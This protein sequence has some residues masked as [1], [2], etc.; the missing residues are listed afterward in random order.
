MEN[1]RDRVIEVLH[2]VFDPELPVNIFELGL[3]YDIKIGD[4]NSVDIIMTLTAPAC[5]VAGDIIFEVQ[6]KVSAVEGVTDA[7]VQL[8]FDPPWTKDMMSEEARLELGF[9]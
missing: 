3:V 9:M 7:H 2:T 6:Q 1:L 5:P 8:T 4:N